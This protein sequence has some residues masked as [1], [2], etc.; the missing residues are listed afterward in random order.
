MSR[1]GTALKLALLAAPLAAGVL[2]LRAFG[3]PAGRAARTASAAFA[4]PE[5]DHGAFR[6]RVRRGSDYHVFVARTLNEFV[7]WTAGAHGLPPP[8]RVTVLLLDSKDDLARFG[9]DAVRLDQGGTADGATAT[10]ALVGDGGTHDQKLDERALRHQMTHLLLPRTAPPWLAE[11]LAAHFETAA[12]AP[13]TGEDPVPLAALLSVPEAEFRSPGKSRLIESA[14][15]LA[16]YLLEHEKASIPG[17]LRGEAS[18]PLQDL[19]T[20]ETRWRLWARR[21]R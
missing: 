12:P 18:G 13:A 7:R 4:Y 20:L 6:V 9:L 3:E 14:R 11:G 10:L 8:A 5:H 15:L 16:A 2:S 17:L 19:P 21:A 1:P